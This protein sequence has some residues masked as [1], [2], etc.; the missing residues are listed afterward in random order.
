MPKKR[1]KPLSESFQHRAPLYALRHYQGVDLSLRSDTPYDTY[2]QDWDDIATYIKV[3]AKR[4]CEHCGHLDDLATRH[5]LTVHHLDMIKSNC[6]YTNLVALCQRCHL[7]VQSC[8]VVNQGW[9]FD[10][11]IPPWVKC[12]HLHHLVVKR[13]DPYTLPMTFT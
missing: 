13:G 4:H 11:F 9:L 3:L 5:T 12:R 10:D 2:P 8:Y 6:L 1:Y 7:Y